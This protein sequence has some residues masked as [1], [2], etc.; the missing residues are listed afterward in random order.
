MSIVEESVYESTN[1]NEEPPDPHALLE[2][3]ENTTKVSSETY[4]KFFFAEKLNYFL[5]P[6]VFVLLVAS[7]IIILMFLRLLTDYK[8]VKVGNDDF[9]GGSFVKFWG[10]LGFLALLNLV[11]L[12]LK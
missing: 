5:L 9:F 2:H 6:L 8:N 12:I 7:E 1:T 3:N 4:Q 11:I 10:T